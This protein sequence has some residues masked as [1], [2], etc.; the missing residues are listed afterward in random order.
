MH[1]YESAARIVG[2]LQSRL[3]DVA[4]PISEPLE[5]EIGQRVCSFADELRD[6]GVSSERVVVE[7]KRLADDASVRGQT[8]ATDRLVTGKAKL[9]TDMVWWCIE[10]YERR[11]EMPD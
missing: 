7:M 8:V 3:A 1:D 6:S 9:L 2:E 4:F 5:R 10:R 11:P